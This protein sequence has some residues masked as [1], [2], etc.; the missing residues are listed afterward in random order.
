[1]LK[2]F[3]LNFFYFRRKRENLMS[4]NN[5]SSVNTETLSTIK[6]K[7]SEFHHLQKQAS[8]MNINSLM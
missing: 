1:M 5:V 3:A 7:A 6:T 8:G 2:Y 4:V